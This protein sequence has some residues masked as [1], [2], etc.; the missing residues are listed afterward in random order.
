[1]HFQVYFELFCRKCKK[2]TKVL[3]KD[4]GTINSP[5]EADERLGKHN[6]PIE[7][8]KCSYCGYK[9]WPEYALFHDAEKNFTFQ[10][11]RLGS[12]DLPVIGGNAHY[13][14]VRSPEEQAEYD[15]GLAKLETYFKEREELFWAEYTKWA[16]ERW[17][18]AL[19]W[20]SELEWKQAYKALKVTG[21]IEFPSPTG[22][23]KDAEKRFRTDEEKSRLWRE[24]NSHLVYFEL[25]W[26]PIDTW[27]V[28]ELIRL[29]GRERITWLLLNVPLPEELEKYRTEKLAAVI[30]AKASGPQAVL[31]ERIKQLGSELTKQRRRAESLARQLIEERAAKAKLE[32]EL[33]IIRNEVEQLKKSNQFTNRNIEDVLRIKRLKT[34]ISEL[35]EENAR[36][37]QQLEEL[38]VKEM[39][40]A[41]VE[42]KREGEEEAIEAIGKTKDVEETIMEQIRDKKVVAYG[43]IGE[44][45]DEGPIITFHNGDKW[46]VDAQRLARES[47]ILVVLT[48]FCSHEVMWSVK[49]YAADTGKP[50]AFSRSGGVEG[51]IREICKTLARGENET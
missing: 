31:W 20:L 33:Y 45:Y 46:D 50:V 48:R 41:E 47:D 51:V 44:T 26:V 17:Q 25:L 3:I 38:G 40:C 2:R 49:E 9:D 10:R 24:A 4:Y 42:H 22:Y 36:L 23:R 16:L 35:R 29:Y 19:K 30:P 18:E 11:V 28:E 37:R 8:I 43:R 6:L 32:E 5:E 7:P 27:P 13:A 34:L 1:M 12:E 39:Q 21:V 14:C 15:R